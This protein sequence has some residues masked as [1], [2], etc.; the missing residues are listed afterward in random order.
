MV[1]TAV[2]LLASNGIRVRD[3]KADSP[4]SSSGAINVY[5]MSGCAENGVLAGGPICEACPEV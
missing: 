1:P 2:L 4:N 3:P 5:A